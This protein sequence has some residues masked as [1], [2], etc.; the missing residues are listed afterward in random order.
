M[1][2][3]FKMAN[4]Q[5]QYVNAFWKLLAIVFQC[6]ILKFSKLWIL[7]FKFLEHISKKMG[8]T[9]IVMSSVRWCVR[10]NSL[11]QAFGSVA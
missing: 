7:F 2:A 1:A 5:F 8:S 4:I 3:E 11:V 9:E 10:L 6:E